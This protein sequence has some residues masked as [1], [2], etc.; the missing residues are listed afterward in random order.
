[1][2]GGG[3]GRGSKQNLLV[4]C[5]NLQLLLGTC[6]WLVRGSLKQHNV[7]SRW[8]VGRFCKELPRANSEGTNP[9]EMKN[10]NANS[11]SRETWLVSL[12]AHLKN[13]YGNF[14]FGNGTVV[15]ILCKN[16]QH[17]SLIS[18]SGLITSF[19]PILSSFKSK[20]AI[21]GGGR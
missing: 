8:Q 6:L 11:L 14:W 2:G 7:P 16:T 20:I 5:C 19:Y 10:E 4:N 17:A 9:P 13:R 12:C 3:E 21:G 1:M 15:T 18:P